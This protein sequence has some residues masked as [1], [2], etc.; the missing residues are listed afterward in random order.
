MA[1]RTATVCDMPQGMV[2]WAGPPNPVRRMC[3]R[4]ASSACVICHR[5]VCAEHIAFRLAATIANLAPP[6][7]PQHQPPKPVLPCMDKTL[8]RDMCMECHQLLTAL[9]ERGGQSAFGGTVYPRIDLET[10]LFALL[11][12]VGVEIGAARAAINLTDPETK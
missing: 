7:N 3:D 1:T 11:D 6:E 10:A 9:K 8:Y 12:A 5:D 4:L 2:S